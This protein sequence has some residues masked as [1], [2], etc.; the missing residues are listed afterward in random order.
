MLVNTAGAFLL[1]AALA[2]CGLTLLVKWSVIEWLQVRASRF[3]YLPVNCEFCLLFWLSVFITL[4][5]PLIFQAKIFYI[6]VPFGAA[7]IAKAI[8]ENSKN[9]LR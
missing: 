1:V 4:C 2:A 9:R 7:T 3:K 5:L 8:Y 6:A